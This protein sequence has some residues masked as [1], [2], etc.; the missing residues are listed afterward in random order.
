MH[1]NVAKRRL[2]YSQTFKKHFSKAP[3]KIQMAFKRRR[4]LFIA[5]PLHPLLRTHKLTGAYIGCRSFNV[6]GDWR[7]VYVD[8]D[9]VVV[10]IDIG[11]HSQLYP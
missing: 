11:T 4:H 5:N 7:A 6:T 2:E 1:E 8:R 3:F 9:E 10:F